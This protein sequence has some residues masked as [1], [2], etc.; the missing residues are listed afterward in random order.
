MNAKFQIKR[1]L[2]LTTYNL[3]P[4]CGQTMLEVLVALTLII[5]F[6]SGVIV[7]QLVSIRNVEYAQ[8]KSLATKLARQQLDR[9]KVIRDTSGFDELI[10]KCLLATCYIDYKNKNFS[11]ALV[12]PTGTFGQSFQLSTSDCPSLS[13]LTPAPTL[14]K[15]SSTVRWGQAIVTPAPEVE[16]S[17]C[18][19]NWK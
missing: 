1:Y 5:L 6:L 3:H 7:I 13:D 19:T 18:M 8:N 17:T 15:A 12:T 16:L 9:A 11:I 4:S 10:S 14:Y 2:Q